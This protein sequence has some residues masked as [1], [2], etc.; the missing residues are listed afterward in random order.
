MLR[1]DDCPEMFA[2]PWNN[3]QAAWTGYVKVARFVDLHS[4]QRV[5]T[6]CARHVEKD[7]AVAHRAIGLHVIT[8]HNLLLLVPVADVEVFL[9]GRKSDAVRPGEI[10]SD[11]LE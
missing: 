3:P 2:F 9:V 5:F 7:F 11:E 6:A 10:L 1:R 8:H 4:V